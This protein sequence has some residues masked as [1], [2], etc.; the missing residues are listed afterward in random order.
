MYSSWLIHSVFSSQA[1]TTLLAET[2][3]ISYMTI[4]DHKTEWGVGNE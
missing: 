4:M 3:V 1:I 2:G